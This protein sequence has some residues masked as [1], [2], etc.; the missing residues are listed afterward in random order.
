MT[1]L[2]HRPAA[3]AVVSV[4]GSRSRDRAST[5]LTLR[6]TE[7]GWSLLA[8]DGHVVFS[9][10]GTAGRRRCLEFARELGVLAVFG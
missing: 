3:F 10:I 4:D 2:A 5:S 1:A 9:A 6:A 7:D 8:A